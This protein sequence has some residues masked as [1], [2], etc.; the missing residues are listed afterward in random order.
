MAFQEGETVYLEDANGKRMFIRVS[1]D[2][3][4]VQS[5]GAIDGSRFKD[6]D[7]GD[8]VSFVGREYTVFR[9]GV[10]EL[11]G[12]LDR[13]AQIITPKDAET[14]IMHCD[15]KCGD[16]VIEVGAGSGGLTT[17][18]LHSVAPTGHVHTLELREEYAKRVEKN[19][20]RCG[21]GGCWSYS[22]GDAREMDTGVDWQAD[23]LTMDM[24]DP[25][26][27]LENLD[28]ALRNGGRLCAYVPNMN[29]VESIVTA[30]RDRGYSGVHALENI[31]RYLEVHPGGVRPSYDTLGH[32]GY[33]VFARKRAFK[34]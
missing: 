5:I 25:W 19:V 22:I 9:P 23:V 10:M 7:D 20:S 27:A 2:M 1:Y 33:L 12:S 24:P 21:Y 34:N 29:Q 32:T 30:L 8:S 31:Q 6:L 26:L 18:L 13:G 15:L 11:M 4:K 16:R 28:F 14:I 17:A 3:V